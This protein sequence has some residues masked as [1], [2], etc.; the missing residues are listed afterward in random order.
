MGLSSFAD[1]DSATREIRL[2]VALNVW[3]K[4]MAA[5]KEGESQTN[6]LG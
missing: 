4:E 6:L 3:A 1:S 2:V 5:S